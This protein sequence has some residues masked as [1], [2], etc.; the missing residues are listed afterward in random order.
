MVQKAESNDVSAQRQFLPDP[1]KMNLLPD[2]E[3]VV[4]NRPLAIQYEIPGRGNTPHQIDNNVKTEDFSPSPNDGPIDTL[5]DPNTVHG[6]DI[7]GELIPPKPVPVVIV[8]KPFRTTIKTTRMITVWATGTTVPAGPNAPYIHMDYARQLVGY[9][10]TRTRL[11]VMVPQ[12]APFYTAVSDDPNFSSYAVVYF[13]DVT[14]YGQN[15]LY[16][17][18]YTSGSAALDPVSDPWNAIVET[19]TSLDSNP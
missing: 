5:P 10:P 1:S 11:Q 14:F 4:I 12:T 8:P 19:E 17:A 6:K 16:V 13:A 18:P 2:G 15:A 9:D 7:Y 3:A